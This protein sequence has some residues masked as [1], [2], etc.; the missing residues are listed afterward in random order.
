MAKPKN[1]K[2]DFASINKQIYELIEKEEVEYYTGII[3][4]CEDNVGI[5]YAVRY[6]IKRTWTASLR[7]LKK[8]YQSGVDFPDNIVYIITRE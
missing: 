5:S 4:F 2:V 8:L 1:I 7:V 6:S 3:S